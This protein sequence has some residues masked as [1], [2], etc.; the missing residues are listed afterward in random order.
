MSTDTNALLSP[1]A[2]T[3]A[4]RNVGG[5][6]GSNK[7]RRPRP[8]PAGTHPKRGHPFPVWNLIRLPVRILSPPKATGMVGSVRSFKAT[9]LTDVKLADVIANK[10]L[11]PLSLKD[12]EVSFCLVLSM[13]ALHQR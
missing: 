9:P 4:T 10:H 13:C 8:T 5:G 11:A 7:L 3:G 12:F 6:G 2:N 1:S